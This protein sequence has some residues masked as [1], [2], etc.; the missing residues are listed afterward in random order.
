ME[1]IIKIIDLVVDRMV[2]IQKVILYKVVLILQIQHTHQ[3]FGIDE[4]LHDQL[5]ID[6]VV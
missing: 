1:L 3:L 5:V 2:D 6:I 4:Y